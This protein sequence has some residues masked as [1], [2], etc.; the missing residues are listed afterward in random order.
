M[1]NLSLVVTVKEVTEKSVFIGTEMVSKEACIH[2]LS[3][4]YWHCIHTLP[5]S[6]LLSPYSC[7]FT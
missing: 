1:L 4:S 5:L 2:S 7:V 6:S 3:P